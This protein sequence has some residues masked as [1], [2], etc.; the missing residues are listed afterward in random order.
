MQHPRSLHQVLHLL[1]KIY[2]NEYELGADQ[3]PSL[4]DHKLSGT[5][6]GLGGGSADA[7]FTLRTINDMFELKLSYD[8]LVRHASVLGSDCAFFIQDNP[9]IGTGRG[10][11]LKP[12]T[13]S[14]KGKFVVLV[15]PNIHVSTS[16][17]FAGIVPQKAKISIN[18]IVEKKPIEAWKDFLVNDFETS[19]FKKFPSIAELKNELYQAG[20]VYSCMSGSGSSVF[21]IFDHA[22][23]LKS[24]FPDMSFWNGVL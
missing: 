2:V 12:A 21:G 10:E 13:V 9:L 22:I 7:A 24:K 1:A 15:K 17:A 19:V 11:I 23:D 8:G 6:A 18:E 16:E 5:G 3:N 14:L 20:A 4:K